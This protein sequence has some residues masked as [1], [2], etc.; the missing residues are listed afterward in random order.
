MTVGELRTLTAL[1]GE[2]GST[3]FTTAISANFGN[4][5]DDAEV[6]LDVVAV[7][8]PPSAPFDVA[9][10]VLLELAVYCAPLIHITADPNPI[11]NA[12]TTLT[13]A[14]RG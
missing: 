13:R 14:G 6:A 7:L 12:Q 1:V 4:L 5:A 3:N 9:A 11:V 10:G 2:L 8:F